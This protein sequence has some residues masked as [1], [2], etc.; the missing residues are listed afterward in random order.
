[1][2]TDRVLQI[3]NLTKG[4]K[5]DNPN[6]N[7]LY[8]TEGIAPCVTDYSGGGNLQPLIIV[9]N[10]EDTD[11]IPSRLLPGRAMGERI[12]TVNNNK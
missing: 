4:A 6:R 3:A 8:D 1:M 2:E 9:T 12:R 11:A 5:R 10:G 7:R